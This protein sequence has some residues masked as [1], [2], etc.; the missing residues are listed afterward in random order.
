MAALAR[1]VA[2]IRREFIAIWA[3]PKT[4]AVLIVPPLVQ[5]L[6][7]SF[8]ATFDVRD[9]PL[10]VLNQDIG[11]Q[12]R[13]LAAA[14]DGS[15]AFHTVARLQDRREIAALID[16][17][18]AKAVLHI[19]PTFSADIAAGRPAPVQFIVDGRHSNTALVA[20]GYAREIVNAFQVQSLAAAP[21]PP[22]RLVVRFW[23]NPNLESRWYV[24]PALVAILILVITTVIAALSVARERELGTFEQLLMTPLRPL[25]MLAGKTIPALI[26]GFVEGLFIALAGHLLFAVPFRGSVLALVVALAV[27]LLSIVGIGLMIS[28]LARTQQQ[29][30]IGAFS[31]LMPAVILSGFA[32]PIANMPDLIQGLTLFNPLRYMLVILRGLFLQDLPWDLVAAQLW[33]MVLIGVVTGGAAAWLFRHRVA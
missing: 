18:G 9:V 12:G 21:T 16:S 30:I 31:F 10:G 8:A 33:P 1:I 6:V 2:L 27:F 28:A 20:L 3:D 4:R 17:A 24:V 5:L 26:I 19:G 13:T 7:F 22:P 29:A 11:P 32:T 25:E 15:A 14:F 23:F